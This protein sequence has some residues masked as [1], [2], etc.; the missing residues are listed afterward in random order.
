MR[1]CATFCEFGVQIHGALSALTLNS[2]T[3]RTRGRRKTFLFL[4]RAFARTNP[5]VR[6]QPLRLGTPSLGGVQF[7]F[8]RPYSN[9][10]GKVRILVVLFSSVLPIINMGIRLL[11]YRPDVCRRITSST[12][13]KQ[14]SSAVG[15]HSTRVPP[16]SVYKLHPGI[17]EHPVSCLRVSPS[18]VLRD[19]GAEARARF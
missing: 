9:I 19:P 7:A 2:I 15:G 8:K 14:P 3:H 10:K 6:F 17:P 18:M 11:V 1:R 5:G 13:L 4:R 16:P 12:E